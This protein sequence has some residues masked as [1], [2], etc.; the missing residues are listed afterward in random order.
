[1]VVRIGVNY[2]K[3]LNSNLKKR[4]GGRFSRWFGR[5]SVQ[6]ATAGAMVRPDQAARC[7]GLRCWSQRRTDIYECPSH[8][9]VGYS[10]GCASRVGEKVCEQRIDVQQDRNEPLQC[11][12]DLQNKECHN[13]GSSPLNATRRFSITSMSF[14]PS[15]SCKQQP[16]R[17][18]YRHR[19]PECFECSALF[20]RLPH[21]CQRC[22]QVQRSITL[23]LQSGVRGQVFPRRCAPP[24]HSLRAL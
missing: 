23:H 16:T 7:T 22:E 1:M 6:K 9:P 8:S 18:A 3:V 5:P 12:W 2:V 19:V 4:N 14:W 20:G 15:S 17:S 24:G 10:A 13:K 21:L 11:H